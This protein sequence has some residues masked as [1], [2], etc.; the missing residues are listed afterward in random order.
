MYS[1]PDYARR[2]PSVTVPS[3][4][5]V[6][7]A[8]FLQ[9]RP[10]GLGV[11][12]FHFIAPAPMK[13]QL[14][15]IREAMRKI[16]HPSRK[17]KGPGAPPESSRQNK[18]PGIQRIPGLHLVPVVGVE[19]TRV[20]S[21]RDFESP[22]SAIPTHRLIFYVIIAYLEVKIKRKVS[23]PGFC[24]GRPA[25]AAGRLR[26]GGVICLLFRLW[27]G[28]RGTAGFPPAARLLTAP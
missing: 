28:D 27:A 26:R 2:P 24:A 18:K 13:K 25:H 20:I 8:P 7:S 22:S 14:F 19:P 4:T 1:Y 5:G 12:C 21:T 23:R 17:R 11:F 10:A 3:L 6:L 15:Q 16:R 9:R